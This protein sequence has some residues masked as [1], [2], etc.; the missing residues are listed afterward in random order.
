VRVKEL[1]ALIAD[2]PDECVVLVPGSDHSYR[3]VDGY[4]NTVAFN[5]NVCHY[6]EWAGEEN[7]TPEETPERALVLE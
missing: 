6:A 2:M 4:D 5:R 7:A 1:K 3:E